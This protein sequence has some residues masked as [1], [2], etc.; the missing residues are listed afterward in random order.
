MRKIR[1]LS[2][3]AF[4]WEFMFL[5]I[6]FPEILGIFVRVVSDKSSVCTDAHAL[7]QIRS[8]MVTACPGVFIVHLVSH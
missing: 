2:G 8:D 4:A 7:R 1:A 6:G 3:G 5:R